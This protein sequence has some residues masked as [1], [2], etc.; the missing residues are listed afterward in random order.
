MY[1]EYITK[2]Q[3]T[4]NDY[5]Y[6][7][8]LQKFCAFLKDGHTNV[9]FP[10]SIQD[11]ILNTDFGEYKIFLS[12]IEG[13]AIITRVNESKKKEIPIGTEIIKINGVPTKKYLKNNVLPYIASSTDYI[14]EDWG[15]RK[16][17][18]RICWNQV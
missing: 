6:F 2:V 17:F 4:K 18:R 15:I 13:K 5:E 3:E 7:R 8:L 14:L 16:T 11:S 1:N 10:K 9:Y 12:N